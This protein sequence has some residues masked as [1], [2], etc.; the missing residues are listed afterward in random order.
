MPQSKRIQSSVC[1]QF[2]GSWCNIHHPMLSPVR[3]TVLAWIHHPNTP[4]HTQTHPD[5]PQHTQTNTPQHTQ[6]HPNTTQHTMQMHFAVCLEMLKLKPC[7]GCS[8]CI[9]AALGR[10]LGA[11]WINHG[12]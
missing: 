7:Q 1:L 4:K 10:V 11:P 9:P 6:T 5:T 12:H 3:K 2:P 8:G